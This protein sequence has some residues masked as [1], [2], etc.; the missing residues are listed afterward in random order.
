[1]TVTLQ[2][3][4]VRRKIYELAG[5]SQGAGS[6]AASTALLGRIFHE[7]FAELAGVDRRRNL[8]DV[9]NE[10]EASF[11]EW[12]TVLVNHTY[13]RLIGPRLRQYHAELNLSPELV[14]TFWDGT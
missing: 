4:D 5:G 13:Q 9:F 3:S 14:L 10:V 12:R 1:M 6:G 11:D 8:Y 2:V 7:T